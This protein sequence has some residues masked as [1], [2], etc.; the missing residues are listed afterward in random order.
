MKRHWLS[1][2]VAAFSV[3]CI[4]GYYI[5]AAA[6]QLPDFTLETKEGDEKEASALMLAGR[7]GQ[8]RYNE[9]VNI[10]SQ[11]SEY[12]RQ[13]SFLERMATPYWGSDELT[14][15]SEEHKQFMRG[16]REPFSFYED[17]DLIAYVNAKSDFSAAA[18]YINLRFT[19][20]V[21]DKK[22][23][24]VSSYELSVPDGNKYQQLM[25]HDIQVVGEQLKVV[26]ENSKTGGSSEV[27]LYTLTK[28]KA[29]VDQTLLSYSSE[30]SPDTRVNMRRVYDTD[31]TAPHRFIAF[32]VVQ[33]KNVRNESGSYTE[34]EVGGQV[35]IYNIQNGEEV[36][37]ESREITDLLGGQKDSNSLNLNTEA[38]HLFLTKE[39]KQGMRVIDYS[40]P[41]AKVTANDVLLGPVMSSKVKNHRLYMLMNNKGDNKQPSTVAVADVNTGQ[42]LYKGTVSLRGTEQ[43]QGDSM[44]KLFVHDII[45]K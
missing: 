27:H 2:V 15:L 17:G 11:G 45:V 37:L 9:A 14:K 32:Y 8:N 31:E 39:S 28:G 19:V 38:E 35:H 16:K 30:S 34:Q 13:R 40:I 42:L 7:F 18:G 29:P 36:K 4:G 25:V 6:T 10:S 24:G 20:S 5:Q 26:T 22:S 12:T 33:T 41:D 21:L 44:S 1:F 3:L 23:K 43:S